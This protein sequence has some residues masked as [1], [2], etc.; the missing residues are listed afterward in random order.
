MGRGI[1]PLM[2]SLRNGTPIERQYVVLETK[3]FRRDRKRLKKT[4]RYDFEKLKSIVRL[5]AAGKNLPAKH[6]DHPLKGDLSGNRECHVEGDWL[7]MYRRQ[8]GILL[9]TLL[10]T[11]THAGMLGE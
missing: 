10:R 11:G 2:T 7:L 4:G 5:L 9:L 6:R 1:I 8:R 3:Q